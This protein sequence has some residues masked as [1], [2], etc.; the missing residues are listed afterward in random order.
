MNS[1]IGQIYQYVHSSVYTDLYSRTVDTN[2]F[3]G[4]FC[5][6]IKGC[7]IVWLYNS[8][9]YNLSFWLHHSLWAND[10]VK[11]VTTEGSSKRT[12][13]ETNHFT[14]FAVLIQYQN[15][16]V[17]H[18]SIILFYSLLFC[19]AN[20]FTFYLMFMFLPHSLDEIFLWELQRVI[21]NLWLTFLW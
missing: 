19:L 5:Y 6:S 7:T 20:Y 8:V 13:C 12:V 15:I 3:N 2:H 14:S 9:K 21:S 18:Q 10:G 1:R 17:W 16:Q 4:L 11:E